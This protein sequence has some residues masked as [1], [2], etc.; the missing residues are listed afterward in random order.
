LRWRPGCASYSPVLRLLLIVVLLNGLVPGFGEALELVVH[1][2]A[3][4]HVAHFEPG[5]SD[6]GSSDQEHGCGPIAHHCGCC[7]SQS[8]VLTP[9]LKVT[10]LV[11]EATEPI[12]GADQQAAI[13]T[14]QRLLRPPIPV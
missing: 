5:E 7:L 11:S 10:Q 14:S 3:S 8:V 13:G 1:Y 4:G 12:L 9:H 6:L 2:A